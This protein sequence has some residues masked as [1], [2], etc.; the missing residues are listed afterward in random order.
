MFCLG[1]SMLLR[2]RV[3]LP[4]LID[5]SLFLFALNIAY[6]IGC[7]RSASSNVSGSW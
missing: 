1:G 4:R 2:R 7:W 6:L 3:R 5:I